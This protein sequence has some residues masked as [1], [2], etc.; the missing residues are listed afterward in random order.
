MI[1][2]RRLLATFM[3]ALCITAFAQSVVNVRVYGGGGKIDLFTNK[4]PFD[5]R[6]LN[7]QSDAFQPQ[8]FVEL[9]ALV[10]YNEEP[11]VNW[12]VAFQVLNPL[13]ETVAVSVNRTD[14]NGI[15]HFG[16]RV[17]WPSEDV[18]EQTVFGVW[19]VVAAVNIAEK[20]FMD[21]LT[22][23]V[24]WIVQITDIKTLNAELS[25]KTSFLRGETVVFNLTV[26]NIALT[27]K[28]AVVIVNV[29]DVVNYPIAHV[30]Y[31]GKPV[32]FQPGKSFIQV[33]VKVPENATVGRATVS[34]VAYTA[35]PV[36]GGVAY[37]PPCLSYFDVLPIP[38]VQYYLTVKTDPPGVVSILG[39]GWYDE[40]ATASLTA[41]EV[42]PISPG[43]RY[44]FKHWSVNGKAL[45]GHTVAFV[46]DRNYTATAHYYLQY[47]LNVVSPY[48]VVGGEG[49]YNA[50]ETA[51]AFLDLGLLDHGNGTR[52]VFVS[53]GGAA[54]GANYS[55]S[56]P[57][58]MDG[59]KTAVANWKTQY[60]LTVATDPAGLRPRPSRSPL[61]EAGPVDGWWY[62]AYVNV[63]LVALPVA[64][65]DFSYWDVDGRAFEVGRVALTVFMN[66]PHVATAHYSVRV[67]GWFLPEWF[68]WILLL[69][70]VLVIILL[71]VW[72]YRRRKRA[73]AGET[74][75]ARGWTAWYYGYDLLGRNR[76]LK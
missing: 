56:G 8:E 31:A 46:M 10:T 28:S 75:F 39:E 42:V 20:V 59:P 57:I 7:R 70:L 26:K 14:G 58:L 25:P 35:L 50:N 22:F 11:I 37:S 60:L 2:G 45:A 21:T 3:L 64:G 43:A 68:Y 18:A 12:L 74:A 69:I 72:I 24:G 34:A 67:V 6:G 44:R 55:K 19:K 41:P 61:G 48:G 76:R 66:R 52:R 15:A 71:C 27:G 13:N 47:Y 30:I 1:T 33:V 17:P 51:Y 38:K 73:K 62:N 53:W 16:F 49:W 9:Y 63:S 4:V 40:G 65:Y 54:S 23:Q 32:I 29:F 36:Y 5:G